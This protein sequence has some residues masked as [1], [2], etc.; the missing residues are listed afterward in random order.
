MP[1]TKAAARKAGKETGGKRKAAAKKRSTPNTTATPANKP[2]KKHANAGMMPITVGNRMACSILEAAVPPQ[3]VA[4]DARWCSHPSIRTVKWVALVS[5]CPRLLSLHLPSDQQDP[6]GDG[7]PSPITDTVIATV[8][9]TCPS[10]QRL[11]L[12]SCLQVSAV[13]LRAIAACPGLQ[14]LNLDQCTGIDFS[15]QGLDALDLLVAS[16]TQLEHLILSGNNIDDRTLGAIAALGTSLHHLN[17]GL[18]Y[19]DLKCCDGITD[20]GLRALA[21]F[22]PGLQHLLLRSGG[23]TAQGLREL[24]SWCHELQHLD[25]GYCN[26]PN[27]GDATAV[28]ELCLR[29]AASLSTLKLTYLKRIDDQCITSITY[30]CPSLQ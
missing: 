13:G 27:T 4:L 26:F 3:L 11:G 5:R 17:A 29:S 12:A 16:C 22:C 9:D 28:T 15:D 19:L 30:Q 2:T 21:T 1:P 7:K 20:L 14:Y 10:L 23:I 18:R 24:A 25:L 6:G 8:A